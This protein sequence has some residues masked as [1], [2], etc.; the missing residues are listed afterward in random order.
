MTNLNNIISIDVNESAQRKLE[1][2]VENIC[3]KLM[4]NETY[5][6]NLISVM[7]SLVSLLIEYQPHT[8]ITISYN[9]DYQDVTVVFTGVSRETSGLLKIQP[10]NLNNDIVTNIFTI[11]SLTKDILI[12]NNK[13][14]FV[15]DIEAMSSDIYNRRKGFLID[16]FQGNKIQNTVNSHDQIPF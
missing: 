10:V 13:L 15:F 9:T 16:Y 6:G 12:D 8:D 14:S 5:F 7:N 4:I 1:Q 2:F 11:Q 3:D